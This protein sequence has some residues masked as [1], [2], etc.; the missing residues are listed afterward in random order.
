M[1]EIMQLTELGRH[2]NGV[3][4]HRILQKQG[5]DLIVRLTVNSEKTEKIPVLLPEDYETGQYIDLILSGNGKTSYTARLLGK[6]PMRFV[7]SN[8]ESVVTW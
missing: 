3:T 2:Q 5:N 6:T 1:N 4:A 8:G 7:P